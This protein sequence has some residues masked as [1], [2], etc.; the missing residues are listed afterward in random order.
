MTLRAA[1]N[2]HDFNGDR[3]VEIFIQQFQKVTDINDWSKTAALLHIRTHL[4]DDACSCGSYATLKE[5]FKELRSKYR[6]SVREART[7]LTNL[8]R[9]TKLSLTGHATEVKKLVEVANTDLSRKHQEEMT[10]DLFF[11]SLNHATCRD[12][13]WP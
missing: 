6:L 5:V 1:F 2:A 4:Q 11:N 13:C 7:R 10:P 9:N 3:D 12:T 8:R